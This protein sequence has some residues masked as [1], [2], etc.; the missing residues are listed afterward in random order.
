[1]SRTVGW[2]T[3]VVPV[4]L[5]P[6]EAGPDAL[7]GG[8][9]LD[10]AVARIREH[11]TDLPTAGIGHGLLRHLNP[12]TGPLLAELGDPQIEFNY[13]GR[14]DRPAAADWS[15]AAEESAAD[16]DADPGMPMSRALTLN[17]LAEDRPEGPELSAHWAYAAE[18]LTEDAVRALA[19]TW[20]RALEA[21]VVRAD[22]PNGPTEPT[23]QTER[24]GPADMS[25]PFENPDGLYSVLVNDEGRHSLWPDFVDV[26]AGSTVVHGPA[27]RQECLDPIETRWTDLRPRSLV[28]GSRQTAR[29]TERGVGAG[30]GP[31]PLSVARYD[32]GFST[33]VAALPSTAAASCGT[34]RSRT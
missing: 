10:G 7:A 34:R 27:G 4:R 30:P 29:K 26:P 31:T 18:L 28:D 16:L 33:F 5:D 15:Y 17:A 1:M 6:G 8:A 13:M 20:F 14:F 2:F 25:N 23:E 12:V 11:L 32:A 22:E 19:E 21:L 3:S 24:Q 9:A